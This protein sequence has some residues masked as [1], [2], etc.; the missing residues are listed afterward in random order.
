MSI[1]CRNTESAV[2]DVKAS[3]A[4]SLIRKL[5]FVDIMPSIVKSCSLLIPLGSGGTA[6][7]RPSSPKSSSVVKLEDIEYQ[8]MSI[9]SNSAANPFACSVA[10]GSLRHVVYKDGAEFVFRVVEL[11][12]ILR[13]VSYELIETDA[14]VNVSSVLHTIQLHEVT[15]TGQTMISWTTDFSGDCDQHVYNDCKY[16][17]LD[18]FRDVR[19][20][21]KTKRS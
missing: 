21:F 7:E 17:K 14:T 15:E 18:A 12:D 13:Q 9:G 19:E 10:V 11:S 2:I 6:S 16:K 20:V 5:N 1:V 4:W 8:D 3:V